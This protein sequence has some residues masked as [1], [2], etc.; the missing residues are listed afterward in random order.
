MKKEFVRNPY[1]YDSDKLSDETGLA[2]LDESKTDQ[3]FVEEADV[4]FIADRYMRTG[5][6]PQVLDMPTSGDF[7]GTFDFQT[8]ANLIIAAQQE[9]MKLPAKHRARFANNPQLLMEFLE[10]DDNYEE[11]VKMGYI[12]PERAKARRAAQNAAK[13]HGG[14]RPGP[15]AAGGGGQG[16]K[17]T[18]KPD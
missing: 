5:L 13:D 7:S 10:D 9:F 15:Q 6:A 8:S 4:N 1:N 16:D 3:S 12:D 2:C 18:N 17:G 11:A 14:D